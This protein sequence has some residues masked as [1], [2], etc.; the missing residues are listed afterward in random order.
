VLEV[1]SFAFQILYDSVDKPIWL[2]E[3]A[4]ED[5]MNF[6]YGH[7]HQK[8]VAEFISNCLSQQEHIN[9]RLAALRT[10]G[11]VATVSPALLALHCLK[12]LEDYASPSAHS[13]PALVEVAHASRLECLFLNPHLSPLQQ[14]EMLTTILQEFA[15]RNLRAQHA[16]HLELCLQ[17]VTFHAFAR[18]VLYGEKEY[19]T[20]NGDADDEDAAMANGEIMVGSLRVDMLVSLVD[21]CC[22]SNMLLKSAPESGAGAKGGQRSNGSERNRGCS[23]VWEAGHMALSLSRLSVQ[24]L[25][26]D[27][28]LVR[29]SFRLLL[30]GVIVATEHNQAVNQPHAGGGDGRRGRDMS[31]PAYVDMSDPACVDMTEHTDDDAV[32]IESISDDSDTAGTSCDRFDQRN[33]QRQYQ[34]HN[35]RQ[36][37]HNKHQRQDAYYDRNQHSPQH[38]PQQQHGGGHSLPQFDGADDSDSDNNDDLSQQHQ[39]QQHQHQ[40]QHRYFDARDTA[41]EYSDELEQQLQQIEQAHLAKQTQHDGQLLTQQRH[42]QRQ[43]KVQQQQQQSQ[44]HSQHRQYGTAAVASNF[45]DEDVG[46]EHSPS[47]EQDEYEHGYKQESECS[48]REED[49]ADD[50]VECD[51]N[52]LERARRRLLVLAEALQ[53][54]PLLKQPKAKTKATARGKSRA[55]NIG[56]VNEDSYAWTRALGRAIL[57]LTHHVYVTTYT[58]YSISTTIVF[59]GVQKIKSRRSRWVQTHSTVTCGVWR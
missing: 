27:P 1:P 7:R 20:G 32:S 28:A 46:S 10:L 26:A 22:T 42:T 11:M 15:S 17:Q 54:A 30:R 37:Q 51:V 50:D 43:R 48:D 12:I 13:A 14:D 47:S 52:P 29:K 56:D 53:Q 16:S 6:I 25:D 57:M 44:G 33:Q 39:H 5:E 23:Q 18:E 58:C 59:T 3:V 9:V 41:L 38:S 40:H 8:S 21:C 34:Q 31:D 4:S 2:E 49:F 55:G 45:G 19:Y 35:N 24:L 36:Y